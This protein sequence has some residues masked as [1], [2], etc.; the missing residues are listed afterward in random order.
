MSSRVSSKVSSVGSSGESSVGS[1]SVDSINNYSNSEDV[2]KKGNELL[3]E[4]EFFYDLCELM[5]DEKFVNFFRKYFTNWPEIKSTVIFIRLFQEISNKYKEIKH[6]DLDKSITIFIIWK[7]MRDKNLRPLTI[8]A[9]NKHY[10]SPNK[11]VSLFDEVDAFIKS[12]H[13]VLALED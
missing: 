8:G 7:I 13:N 4:N 6:E 10:E 2:V 1:M 11:W 9:I 5:E 12:Q 3:I